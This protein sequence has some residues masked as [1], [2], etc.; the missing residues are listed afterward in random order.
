MND[1]VGWI[2]LVVAVIA[3]GI[4]FFI[5][6]DHRAKLELATGYALLVLIFFYGAIVLFKMAA[7][8]IDLSELLGEHGGG[9]SMSRFQLLIFTFV[10]ALSFFLLVTEKGKF[11]DVPGEVLALLGISATTY[12][13]SKGIQASG[14]AGM[15]GKGKGG[16]DTA[17]KGSG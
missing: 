2:T 12:G 10:I 14:G 1:R 7:G 16:N 17:P 13:V 11:P 8:T 5:P 9:A 3:A 6:G 4:I 15:T